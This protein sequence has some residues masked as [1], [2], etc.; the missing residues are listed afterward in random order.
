MHQRV[1]RKLEF[2]TLM[3][4]RQ[5][6]PLGEIFDAPQDL[7]LGNFTVIP[8]DIL[9]ISGGQRDIIKETRFDGAP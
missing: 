2:I 7:T 4:F 9:Y 1:S 8:P 5:T 3:H 6:D